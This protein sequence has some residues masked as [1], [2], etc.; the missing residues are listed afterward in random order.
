MG[1][2]G[3]RGGGAAEPTG[4][5]SAPESADDMPSAP[6]DLTLLALD[7]SLISIE[8]GG[9][10]IPMVLADTR[11]GRALRGLS[12]PEPTAARSMESWR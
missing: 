9:R 1:L 11:T 6:A 5:W 12:G 7:H 10:L 3:H 8:N 2:F 4:A